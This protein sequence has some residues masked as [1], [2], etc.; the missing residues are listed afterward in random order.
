MSKSPSLVDALKQAMQLHAAGRF[1][2]A[3][4]M[5]REILA[6]HPGEPFVTHLLGTLE[7]QTGRLEQAVIDLETA[8]ASG[9]P[10][11]EW[12]IAPVNANAA[13]GRFD[14]AVHWQQRFA[15]MR[16]SAD[17]QLRLAELLSAAGRYEESIAALHQAMALGPAHPAI[18]RN[19]I[20]V[21]YQR[22]RKFELAAGEHRAAIVL[23]PDYAVAHRNL[24]DALRELGEYAAAE[25]SYRDAIQHEPSM[26]DAHNGL[27]LTFYLRNQLAEAARYFHEATRL[28]PADTNPC[29]NLVLC[30]GRLGDHE[31]IEHTLRR[32]MELTP[33]DAA[34]HSTLTMLMNY[35]RGHELPAV[36]NESVEFNR[37]HAAHLLST[38][39]SDQSGRVAPL[40]KDR[41]L[42]IGYIS[43]DFRRHPV[44]IFFE[45]LLWH[46]DHTSFTIACYSNVDRPDDV[47]ARLKSLADL[48]RD[49]AGKSDDEV[50]G[51]IRA[52]NIDI[53]IDLAGHTVDN[54]LLVL[55][56]KPA[57][58]QATWLG[59]PNT[60]GMTVVDYRITD[61]VA[62]PAGVEP[63]YTEKLIRLPDAFFVY[64]PPDEN[65]PVTLLPMI[66]SGFITFGSFNNV[67]KIT[68]KIGRLWSSILRQMPRARLLIAGIPPDAQ[69]R[70]LSF[71]TGPEVAVDRIEFP[72]TNGFAEFLRLHHRV[73]IA[74]DAF[75]YTG[76]T[77]TCNCLWMGVPVVS[78][79]GPTA[80]SRVGASIMANLGLLDEWVATKKEDYIQL[81]LTRAAE[82]ARLQA[83]RS[84]LREKL[85]Q[86]P[87][88]DAKKFTQNFEAALRKCA[89]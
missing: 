49:I 66:E 51:L 8:V 5:Y 62:D 63:F 29:I 6:T 24:G 72:Q 89:S 41:V 88:T 54:S 64:Q 39:T 12:H 53:L 40:L 73:D 2:D 71:I 82:P 80:V 26:A 65:E 19:N 58:I 17:A 61:A 77:T 35:T 87:L 1:P 31:K 16:P 85:R 32:A 86:S 70:M 56:R 27:G 68:P 3:E 38:D 25:R 43:P 11:A 23:Q 83:L 50:A 28:S 81:A 45:P 48:W 14:R 74:L 60:T 59:Y 57:P 75:P 20:G 4:A 10:R 33:A 9:M 52:D 42:R 46:H 79:A 34:V 37:R 22:L 7:M 69:A 47:T 36:L 30:Y 84:S 15:A 76:H 18:C 44:A 13:L 67:T 21:N 78:L 55:A